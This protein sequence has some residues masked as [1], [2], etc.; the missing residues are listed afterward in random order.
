MSGDEVAGLPGAVAVVDGAPVA[1]DGVLAADQEQLRVLPDEVGVDGQDGQ[2]AA[3]G[4]VRGREFQGGL[5]GD[6][7]TDGWTAPAGAGWDGNAIRLP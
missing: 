4:E 6:F 3:V 7:T 5:L 2:G 1:G